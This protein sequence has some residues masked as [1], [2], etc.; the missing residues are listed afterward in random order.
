V[1]WGEFEVDCRTNEIL[2]EREALVSDLSRAYP[3]AAPGRLLST[4]YDA[5]SGRIEIR[6][7]EAPADSELVVFYPAVK[8]GAPVLSGEGLTDVATTDG[9][10]GALYVTARTVGGSWALRAE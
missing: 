8:H 6:G 7:A 5:A 9:P 1:P 10:G 2:G 3:R 4:E